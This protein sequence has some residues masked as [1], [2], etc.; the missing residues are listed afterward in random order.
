MSRLNL[1][2]GAV[3][4]IVFTVAIL[5][6][7]ETIEAPVPGIRAASTVE[8]ADPARG[9]ELIDAYG[10]GACHTIPGVRRADGRVGPNLEDVASQHYIAGALV[11]TPDNLARWIREPQSI[12]PGTA[13]PD[14]G[15]TVQESRDVAAYLYTLE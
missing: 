6:S 8:G 5:V 12:E 3:V 1:I 15:L 9:A 11:T 2:A 10:C 7:I 14:L 13:M 4:L